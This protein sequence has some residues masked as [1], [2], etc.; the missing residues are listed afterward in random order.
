MTRRF[1]EHAAD[2]GHPSLKPPLRTQISAPSIT[3]AT[4]RMTATTATTTAADIVPARGESCSSSTSFTSARDIQDSSVHGT[5]DDH[6][7]LLDDTTANSML[8]SSSHH[9]DHSADDDANSQDENGQQGRRRSSVISTLIHGGTR[10]DFLCY[11]IHSWVLVSISKPP[12]EIKGIVIALLFSIS[13]VVVSAQYAVFLFINAES[14]YPPCDGVY[15]TC[16]EG[17]ICVDREANGALLCGVCTSHPPW[18]CNPDDYNP[19]CT[20]GYCESY[21]IPKGTCPYI[22]KNRPSPAPG[23]VIVIILFLVASVV[24][25]D[26]DQNCAEMRAAQRHL[27]QHYNDEEEEIIERRVVWKKWLTALN[28]TCLNIMRAYVIPMLS[29]SGLIAIL[30]KEKITATNVLLNGLAIVLVGGE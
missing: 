5:N 29:F 28:L 30:Y 21:G 23:I 18:Y 20:E 12:S 19:D 22:E 26:M 25:Q 4:R 2:E 15:H 3:T 9:H 13:W 16:T 1:G 11:G 8:M 24:V 27:E 17:Q 6:S 10:R 7:T 14:T